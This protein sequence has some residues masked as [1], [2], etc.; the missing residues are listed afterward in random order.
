MSKNNQAR[1]S[2][3]GRIAVSDDFGPPLGAPRRRNPAPGPQSAAST[4]L[5]GA[6]ANQPVTSALNQPI[7]S[8]ATAS[9]P[10][11][12]AWGQPGQSVATP[13]RQPPTPAESKSGKST[14]KHQTKRPITTAAAPANPQAVAAPA[15]AS[16]QRS[17][18]AA[19]SH[20][21]FEAFFVETGSFLTL[22]AFFVSFL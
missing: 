7:Q 8:P 22:N 11:A 9:Q 13:P 18:G 3:R 14:I 20:G 19:S 6:W 17:A 5:A 1:G 2:G 4:A 16:T 12:S 15:A 21:K 10:I